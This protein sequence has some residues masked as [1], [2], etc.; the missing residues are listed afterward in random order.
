MKLSASHPGKKSFITS[1]A[2]AGPCRANQDAVV[3]ARQHGCIRRAS[4][5][6]C[7]QSCSLHGAVDDDVEAALRLVPDGA[8]DDQIVQDAAV[9]RSAEPSA[10]PGRVSA[11]GDVAR[12]QFVDQSQRSWRGLHRR[13]R[14]PSSFRIQE[15]WAHMGDIEQAGMCPRPVVLFHHAFREL[16]RHLIARERH[17]LRP[18]VRHAGRKAGSAS[19]S[20]WLFQPLAPSSQETSAARLAAIPSPPLSRRLRDSA[21]LLRACSVGEVAPDGPPLS[22]VLVLPRSLLPERFRG[23]CAF[24]GGFRYPLSPG[25]N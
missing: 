20:R 24:G 1:H 4:L 25:R 6:R 11:S 16:D 17:Q 13:R 3:G 2:S 22:S 15:A 9:V 7:A 21:R 23:G 12:H 18:A 5:R 14:S 8:G 19:V 10:A